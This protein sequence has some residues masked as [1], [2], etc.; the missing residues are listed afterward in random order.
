MPSMT[1]LPVNVV[2]LPVGVVVPIAIWFLLLL[3]FLS[4]LAY[5][6]HIFHPYG[7]LKMKIRLIFNFS[8]ACYQQLLTDSE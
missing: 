1:M 6:L 3:W 5:Q 7:P 4:L 2:L 8:I